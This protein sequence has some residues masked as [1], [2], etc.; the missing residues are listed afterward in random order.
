MFFPNKWSNN[1]GKAGVHAHQVGTGVGQKITRRRFLKTAAGAGIALSILGIERAD[2][3]N[4]D[5][6]KFEPPDGKIYTGVCA[7]KEG[8]SVAPLVD[9]WNAWTDAMGGKPAAISHTF[10][11]LPPWFSFDFETADARNA[12]AALISWQTGDTSPWAISQNDAVIEKVSS[13]KRILEAAKSVAL[14]K[15][16]VFLRI[17]QEMN[18]HWMPWC[19]F[20][21]DGSPRNHTPHDFK[22]M[23]RRIH[24]LYQ[25][26]PVHEV[27]ARLAA[28]DL[29]PV[30]Y[31]FTG[32]TVFPT[33][34]NVAFVFN[35]D[36]NPGAP[37][38]DE[39][40]WADYYPGDAYVDW[41]GQTFY[42]AP[43]D[44][45]MDQRFAWL[46]EFYNN[47]CTPGVHNKPYMMGEWGLASAAWSGFGD[48]PQF[49]HRTLDW[50]EAKSKVKSIV[51]FEVENGRGHR[52]MRHPESGL[53]YPNAAAALR[54]RWLASSYLSMVSEATT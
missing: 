23:W 15:K 46:E 45:S 3:G 30:D 35:P 5:L 9:R 1:T 2:A 24:I 22:Q 42:D 44:D 38:V 47:F 31:S 6:G 16:P 19:A 20:N 17:N 33:V 21:G 37:R 4:K 12:P 52:I 40:R 27:N 8:D 43:H 51:Y 49:I 25:G 39:N 26:G 10:N 7:S 13:D 32:D 48:D 14:W 11:G 34:S 18:A 50:A 53:H 28:V 36:N 29:P 41:V 54:N